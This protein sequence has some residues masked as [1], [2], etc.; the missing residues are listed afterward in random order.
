MIFKSLAVC[1]NTTPYKTDVS[2]K[3][4][5]K[6]LK[7]GKKQ[8]R[9]A[10]IGID[11]YTSQHDLK[12]ILAKKKT[13]FFSDYCKKAMEHGKSQEPIA[14]EFYFNELETSIIEKGIFPL[15]GDK[16]IGCSPD[17]VIYT[18]VPG[19]DGVL[20]VKE[21]L[22]YHPKKVFLFFIVFVINHIVKKII[23]K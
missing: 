17:G 20:Q 21:L 11:P 13:P 15:P 5:Y 10:A 16:R 6:E 19:K 2:M 12:L 22:K 4:W 8:E 1:K 14:R 23:K 18:T 3:I 7:N 9:T